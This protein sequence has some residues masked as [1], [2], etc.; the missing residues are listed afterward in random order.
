MSEQRADLVT[1][2]VMLVLTAHTAEVRGDDLTAHLERTFAAEVE[3]SKASR[4]V[5][6]L[7][8]VKY[9]TS[10]GV[11]VLLSL[12]QT[13]KPGGGRIVLCGL[14]EMVSEVLQLMRFID[15]SGSRLTPFEVQS[16]AKA[17]VVSLLTPRV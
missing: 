8:A 12:Y 15:P 2:N 14:S 16:D 3:R 17:A 1:S 9:I 6:D 5:I 13:V 10:I 4:V 11:R 7:T